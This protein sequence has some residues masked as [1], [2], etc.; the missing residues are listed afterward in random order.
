MQ[1]HLPAT[2][3]PALLAASLLLGSVPA[4]AHPILEVENPAPNDMLTPG[5]MVMQGIAY[6]H[7]A[8]QGAGVD[9]V[10]IFVCPRG[11]GGQY[12]GDATLGLPANT[13]LPSDQFANSG[14]LLKTPPLKGSGEHRSLCVF[15]RSSATGTETLV[16]IPVTIGEL[17]PRQSEEVVAQPAEDTASGPLPS[18][19]GGGEI[20]A[21]PGG[22][23][24]GPDE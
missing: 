11:D 17:R 4:A 1:W 10:S 5:S 23:D 20:S 15:A 19:G 2:L 14:W 13:R 22:G 16:R 7:D 6:D 3:A 8:T 18:A 21:P 9:K 24:A 12:L